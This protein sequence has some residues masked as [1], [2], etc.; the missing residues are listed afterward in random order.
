[1]E[2]DSDSE[3]SPQTT[4]TK[5][6]PLSDIAL[7]PTT[8]PNSNVSSTVSFPHATLA[9]AGVILQFN[10]PVHWKVHFYIALTLVD[11]FDK[12]SIPKSSSDC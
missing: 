5:E 10:V 11:A 4:S 12:G 7:P 8:Y 3:Q 1:M 9:K 6:T 2:I